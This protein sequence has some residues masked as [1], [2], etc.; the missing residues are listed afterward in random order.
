MTTTAEVKQLVE[1]YAQEAE[2]VVFAPSGLLA[3]DD[4]I[5]RLAREVVALANHQGGRVVLGVSESGRFEGRLELERDSLAAAVDTLATERIVPTPELSLERLAGEEGELA[6]I[7][8]E[9]RVAGPHAV[10]RKLAGGGVAARAYF[11]RDGARTR[12]VSEERLAWM[13]RVVGDPAMRAEVELDLQ[14]E[15]GRLEVDSR[16]PLPAAA[17]R[18]RPV[19]EAVAGAVEEGAELDVRAQGL[20]ELAAWAFL[21]ELEEAFEAAGVEMVEVAL[22]DLPVPERQSVFGDV[23]DGLRTLLD[24]DRRR[25]G[26][27]GLL[28]KK[29]PG[30]SYRLPKA[31]ELQ[32]DYLGRQGKGRLTLVH[33]AV[34]L[35]LSSR[36]ASQGRGA[37]PS[38]GGGDSGAGEWVRLAL[39]LNVSLRWDGVHAAAAERASRALTARVREHWDSERWALSLDP[40]WRDR[41]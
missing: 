29:G 12:P 28:G 35:T 24:G 19:L 4:G 38:L 5:D 9:P 40:A 18:F 39:A 8:V 7:R 17:A 11:V 34:V 25:G 30:R 13:F 10:A 36:V 16:R 2:R 22:D 15:P 3:S 23:G 32:V 41:L 37:A 14:L 26:I 21:A 6:V 1:R 20:N 27:A 33:P 31:A